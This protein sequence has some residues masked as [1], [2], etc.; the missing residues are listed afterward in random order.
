MLNIVMTPAIMNVSETSY[1]EM[2]L[3]E[4]ERESKIYQ[5]FR[6]ESTTYKYLLKKFMSSK[7]PT[8]ADFNKEFIMIRDVYFRFDKRHNVSN[9]VILLGQMVYSDYVAPMRFV[10]S[11]LP[12]PPPLPLHLTPLPP[13]LPLNLNLNLNLHSS[14][15]PVVNVKKETSMF[16][17]PVTLLL[18]FSLTFSGSRFASCFLSPIL[19]AKHVLAIPFVPS[20]FLNWSMGKVLRHAVH[21][22]LLSHHSRKQI[23]TISVRGIHESAVVGGHIVVVVDHISHSTRHCPF[24]SRS[25]CMNTG[26]YKSP[27]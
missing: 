13:P 1:L 24:Q 15:P 23:Q 19:Q 5:S 21:G 26:K 9:K 27:L 17:A 16:S 3:M 4:W 8:Y 11:L 18:R 2:L 12:L 6:H 14:P 10:P 25:I 22:D 20:F 7:F